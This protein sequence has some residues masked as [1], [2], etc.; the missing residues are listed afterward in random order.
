MQKRF[1]IFDHK[2]RWTHSRHHHR[3]GRSSTN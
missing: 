2:S 3:Q 1:V